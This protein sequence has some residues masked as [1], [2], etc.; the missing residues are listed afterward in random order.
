SAWIANTPVTAMMVAIGMSILGFLYDPARG[1]GP[2]VRPAY[3]TGLMLMTTFGASVGGLATPIGSAPNLIG[4]GLIRRLLG[5]E[6]SFL[7][8]CAVGVPA[9]VLLFL[10][11]SSY[12]SAFCRAGVREIPG[13]ASMLRAERARLGPWTRGQRSTLLACAVTVTLWL[14]PGALALAF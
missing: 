7:K 6:F 1:D 10:Y 13:G 4:L 3:A 9:A 5:V 2:P 14:V 12:L 8:W 11:L